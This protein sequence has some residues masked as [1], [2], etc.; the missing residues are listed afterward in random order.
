[1]PRSCLIL[2]IATLGACSTA[3]RDQ[4]RLTPPVTVEK[5]IKGYPCRPRTFGVHTMSM[6]AESLSMEQ[7]GCALVTYALRQIG[8]GAWKRFGL[9]ESDSARVIFIRLMAMNTFAYT[10][11]SKR[12]PGNDESH[13]SIAIRVRDPDRSYE[14][15]IDRKTGAVGVRTTHPIDTTIRR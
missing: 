4:E 14:A 9:V 1:M 13:Y 2:A 15:V 12:D 5:L 3:S 7:S 6:P 10:R 8:D 11:D